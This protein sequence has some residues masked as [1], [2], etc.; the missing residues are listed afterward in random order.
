MKE[1]NKNADENKRLN[2]RMISG[3]KDFACTLPALVFLGI[4]TYYPIM[5]LFRISFTNWNLLNDTYEYV[6]F[7]NW[8]WLFNGSGTKHLLN[9]L[10]VTF[11]YSLGELSITIIGGMIFALIFN[12]MTKGFSTMR[13]IV[14]V[15]KYVAMSSAA[16]IYLWIL[17]TD[18][19]ILNY[20]LSL[21]GVGPV[22][23]LGDRDTALLS[24]LL[25]TGWRAVGYGM[26]VYLSA[27]LG[28]SQD[29]YEAAALDG[30]NKVQIF[31]KITLPM[32]S[33]TTL[34]L[35]VTTFI[36]SMK[37]F[38]SVDIL[39]KGGPYRSTEVFVYKIYQYAMVDFRM[40]RASVIA[41]FFFILL[42]IV[43]ALTMKISSGNVTYDS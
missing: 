13:A 33:P 32:L 2:P 19:G 12:R 27:M 15:P 31:F 7:K 34:F 24:V 11:L 42:L 22:D 3:L 29:Y 4:F 16:V 5:E 30:A 36:S 41:I 43:T 38:Q 37:V 23:W 28:I 26:M 1:F 10:K 18:S 6:G 39:T 40:D 25:L 35:F 17:N 14:F 9:S 20:I 8:I 21:F